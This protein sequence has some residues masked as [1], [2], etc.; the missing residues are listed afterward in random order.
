MNRLLGSE[1]EFNEA[2]NLPLL[3]RPW[4]FIGSLLISITQSKS[5]LKLEKH[6]VTFYG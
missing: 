4:S 3:W 6:I 5:T 2:K 1:L